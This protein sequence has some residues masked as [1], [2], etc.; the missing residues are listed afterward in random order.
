MFLLYDLIFFAVAAAASIAFTRRIR[1]ASDPRRLF[2]DRLGFLPETFCTR[3]DGRP[4]VW[5]HAVSV[6]EVLGVSDFVQQAVRRFP[7][8]QFVLSTTTPT[9]FEIA[10]TLDDAGV[11]VFYAP[12]D[13]S[14][15]TSRVVRA[16]RPQALLIMETELWPNLIRSARR[17]GV[18]V[19]LVNGRLS[20]RSFRGYRWIRPLLKPLLASFEFLAVQTAPDRERFIALG[21][22]AERVHVTGSMKFDRR[23][24]STEDP[25]A[26]RGKLGIAKNALVWIAGSTHP[27]EEETVWDAYARLRIRF[28]TLVL[29]LAPRHVERTGELVSALAK[30]G[31][32]VSR[33]SCPVPAAQV[34]VVDEI[35]HLRSLYGLADAVFVGGSLVR[36]GGQN[37]MEAAALKRSVVSGPHVFNFQSVYDELLNDRAAYRVENTAA[38]ASAVEELLTDRAKAEAMGLRAARVL[39]RLG[40]A[41][42]RHLGF[43]DAAVRRLATHEPHK[44]FRFGGVRFFY[45][46]LVREG[47]RNSL[48][49]LLALML[50]AASVFYGAGVFTARTFHIRVIKPHRLS[51]PVVSVGNLTW[52]GTGKTPLVEYVA[53]Y[54]LSKGKRPLILTRGYGGDEW[55]ELQERLPDARLA[56]GPDRKRAAQ[57]SAALAETQLAILDDGFQHWRLHRDLDVVAVHALEA[58]GNRQ[59]IP[60]GP[61]REPIR[62]LD[63]ADLVV[64]THVHLADERRLETLRRE[65]EVRVGDHLVEAVHE[66]QYL[67]RA[68]TG[69][70][71]PLKHLLS[72]TVVVFSGIGQPCTFEK[73]LEGTGARLGRA[74]RF[75]DHHGYSVEELRHIKSEESLFDAVVTTEK[76][77]MRAP[78]L[79]KEIVDPLVLRVSLRLVRGEEHLH[80]SL[81]RLLDR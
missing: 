74:L 17:A 21:A 68:S 54:V 27:G 16:L 42:E 56:V 81:D 28:P 55:K 2:F 32:R 10:R 29:V 3:L 13:L 71:M 75:A 26:L 38:L 47:P 59:L 33:F 62:A 80:G 41:V 58:F 67:Y 37:P 70:K 64:L 22:P 34:V 79:I 46:R 30:R 60:A 53:R 19:G 77:L 57:G 11:P 73:T 18:R 49:G 48:E 14:F 45:L 69:E 40:G 9:G 76:D 36:H 72:K 44:P 78:A 52:G 8:R 31:L 4:V 1:Q 24:V 7:D 66:P 61:L 35:G 20:P 23:P 39:E 65:L 5:V 25:C 50:R 63:R 43:L 12:F 51:L 6:G 15:I